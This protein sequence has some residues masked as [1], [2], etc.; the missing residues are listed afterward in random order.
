MFF[1]VVE[2]IDKVFEIVR[3][4]PISAT[5][6]IHCFNLR[7]YVIRKGEYPYPYAVG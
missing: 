4:S 5:S 7:R 1:I 6:S 3:P 2:Y